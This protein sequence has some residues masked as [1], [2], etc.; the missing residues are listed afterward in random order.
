MMKMWNILSFVI[1]LLAN[2]PLTQA[3]PDC[4]PQE[5]AV[6]TVRERT[7]TESPTALMPQIEV[8]IC[9]DK[10]WRFQDVEP[11]IVRA[12]ALLDAEIAAGQPTAS[13]ADG[14]PV[15]GDAVPLPKRTRDAQPDYPTKAIVAG[16][17]G[18]VDRKS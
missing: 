11:A 4:S 17:T 6:M 16:I 1:S 18:S 7:A 2:S 10:A 15:A 12:I 13:R 9:Y 3:L 14:R 8:A 5:S